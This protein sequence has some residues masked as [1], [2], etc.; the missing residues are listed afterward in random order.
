MLSPTADGSSWQ[1]LAYVNNAVLLGNTSVQTEKADTLTI[2]EDTPIERSF[3][4]LLDLTADFTVLAVSG[5]GQ[6][7]FKRNG[8]KGDSLLTINPEKD[9]SG[10]STILVTI[11]EGTIQ[12]TLL[13]PVTVTNVVDAPRQIHP[14]ELN[15]SEDTPLTINVSSLTEAFLDPDRFDLVKFVE[16]KE[17][18]AKSPQR[19]DHL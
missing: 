14:L 6:L 11:Q 5:D 12:R 9:F 18:G 17:K 8:N 2:T 16:L 1:P 3:N 15:T 19:D 10:S 4:T 7:R 13:V